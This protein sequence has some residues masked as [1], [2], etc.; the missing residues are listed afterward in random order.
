MTEDGCWEY[1]DKDDDGSDGALLTLTM[2]EAGAVFT[3]DWEDGGDGYNRS[4]SV[5]CVI[6]IARLPS[7]ISRLAA[8]TPTETERTGR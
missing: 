3:I 6:P 7:L 2:N 5:Q 4:V 1:H 8:F